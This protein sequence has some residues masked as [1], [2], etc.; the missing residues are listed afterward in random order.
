MRVITTAVVILIVIGVLCG[1][2]VVLPNIARER[3]KSRE[4]NILTAGAKMGWSRQQV[5]DK[6]GQ[7]TN[8][9]HSRSE[10]YGADA[11]EEVPSWPIEHE[12]LEY[13]RLFWKLYVYID[14]RNRVSRTVLVRT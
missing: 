7:P 12:V 11:Y 5:I 1:L 10:F 3:V 13:N 2:A 6:L 14:L 8:V 9:A 4:R